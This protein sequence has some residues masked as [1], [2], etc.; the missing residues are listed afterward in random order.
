MT[1]TR[2]LSTNN[3]GPAKFIVDGTSTA[4]GTHST[5]A[6]ALTSASSGDTIFIRPGTYTEN[7]TLKAGVNLTAYGSDSSLNGTGKV[8]ISGTCTLT[9]AGTVTISGIQLQTNSAVLLAVT[10]TAAS[11]V[12]LTNCYLNCSNNTGITF[13]SSDAGSQ[14]NISNCSGNLGTTGIAYFSDSSAGTLKI[15]YSIL[16]NSGVST[17][18]STKSAGLFTMQQSTLT[19]PL[20]YSSSNTSSSIL[21]CDF[22]CSAINTTPLT[23]SGTGTIT[24]QHSNVNGGTA[25][26]ISIGAG[27]TVAAR[28]NVLRSS[29]ANSVTGAGTFE[30]SSN[31]LF[32]TTS[33]NPTTQNGEYTQLAQFRASQQ[34]AFLATHTAGQN[35]VTGNGTVA[36][37]NFTSEVF[38]QNSNYDGTNT[39]T[40]P[41]TGKYQFNVSVRFDAITTGSNGSMF[42]V[43]SNRSY[44]TN[45]INYFAVQNGG[46]IV[47]LTMSVLADMDAADTAIV[48]VQI[49]GAGADTVDL[50]GAATQAYF[51]GYL[52]A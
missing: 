17:T 34:P 22:N 49:A 51:S 47:I 2:A 15:F 50:G 9:T 8:I 32:T 20:T 31:T 37:V 29:A 36:T 38:D 30:H 26:A 40:A 41:I 35:N 23:T 33:I 4:N 43:T 18:A 28:Q 3:Y 45:L 27:T 19:S 11:I 21:N 7:L 12:N 16:S 6:S 13:S 25:A 24:I 46:N 14:I 1:F 44:N 48:Q 52:V 10:G 39:F 5:I 42:I